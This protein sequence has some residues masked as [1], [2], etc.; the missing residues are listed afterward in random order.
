MTPQ[1]LDFAEST[2]C[3]TITEYQLSKDLGSALAARRE[4][5]EEGVRR[6]AARTGE[7]VGGLKSYG[8]RSAPR[9]PA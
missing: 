6:S 3:F 5:V 1:R 8:H 7:P 2:D 4:V 9:C